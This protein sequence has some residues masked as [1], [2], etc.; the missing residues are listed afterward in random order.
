VVS[1]SFDI[2]HGILP[3]AV[4]TASFNDVIVIVAYTNATER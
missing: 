2:D 3:L 4:I 1:E